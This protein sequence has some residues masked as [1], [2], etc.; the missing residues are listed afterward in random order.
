MQESVINR[1][2]STLFLAVYIDCCVVSDNTIRICTRKIKCKKTTGGKTQKFN[3]RTMERRIIKTAG[4]K[5]ISISKSKN[6][7]CSVAAAASR[8]FTT[9]SSG[10]VF[11]QCQKCLLLLLL[12]LF[13]FV[14][15]CRQL[16]EAPCVS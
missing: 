3:R 15:A 5:S 1:Y 10:V 2:R 14:W 7:D 6:T 11:A 13:L 16:A 9:C 8:Q 4:E 12:L